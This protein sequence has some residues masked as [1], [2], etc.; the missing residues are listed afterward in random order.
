M[1]NKDYRNKT[2]KIVKSP[3]VTELDGEKV[4]IDFESGKYFMIKG[5]GNAIYEKLVDGLSVDNLI[6]NLIEE[7]DVS[8]EECCKDTYEF[9]EKLEKTGFILIQ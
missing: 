3:D 8:R 2:I 4:M 7:F 5:C 1:D 6:S 9:L